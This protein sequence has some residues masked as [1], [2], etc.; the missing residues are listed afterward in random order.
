MPI[1]GWGD[2]PDTTGPGAFDWHYGIAYNSSNAPLSVKNQ[3]AGV[4]FQIL[5]F[6]EQENLHNTNNANSGTPGIGTNVYTPAQ[7]FRNGNVPP[8]TRW[9]PG[10]YF[11]DRRLNPTGPTERGVVK[12]YACPSRRAAQLMQ[13][14]APTDSFGGPWSDS[15]I[16]FSDYAVVRSVPVPVF[17]NSAGFYSPGADPNIGHADWS[18]GTFNSIPQYARHSV[19]G[20]MMTRTT[21]AS[22]KDGSSNTMV[23]E[24][25][26]MLAK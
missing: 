14:G 13:R 4:L 18:A 1:A 26:L 15:P 2:L 21:F 20:P 8:D 11:T 12:I 7:V 5:P 16:G 10:A 23:M 24:P 19:I 25:S 17:V 9:P 22:I 3:S 6:V